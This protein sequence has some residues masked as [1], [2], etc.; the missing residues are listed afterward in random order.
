MLTSLSYVCVQYV[1]IVIDIRVW[2]P[3]AAGFMTC[4]TAVAVAYQLTCQTAVKRKVGA[5]AKFFRVRYV[6]LYVNPILH[7]P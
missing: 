4:M 6:V 2:Q 1:K 7:A 5:R 3:M